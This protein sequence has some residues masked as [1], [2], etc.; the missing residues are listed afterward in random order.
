M[1][2]TYD[3]DDDD[4]SRRVLLSEPGGK[5]PRGRHRLRWEDG[6]EEHVARLGCRNRSS[7][8]KPGRMEESL[9]GGRGPPRAVVLLERERVEYNETTI[10]YKCKNTISLILMECCNDERILRIKTYIVITI[11]I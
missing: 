11:F 3:Q 4:L 5:R 9:E 7:R 1:G 10:Q 2:K 6:V 8:P